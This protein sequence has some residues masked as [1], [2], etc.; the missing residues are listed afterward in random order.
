MD[1]GIDQCFAKGLLNMGFST[2]DRIF[3]EFEGDIKPA[4]QT[5]I[6]TKVKLEQVRLPTA[7][8]GE[9]IGPTL[10]RIV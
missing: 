5:T 4:D 6:D 2:S 8:K 1:E 9:S 7:I 3:V 10:F